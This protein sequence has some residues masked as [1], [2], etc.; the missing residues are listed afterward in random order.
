MFE[1][2]TSQRHYRDPMPVNEAFDHLVMNIGAHFD[3]DCV[4]AMIK[5]YNSKATVPYLYNSSNNVSAKVDETQMFA[6]YEQT[7]S[8]SKVN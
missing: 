5:Y 4:E 7:G 1:A 8:I 3:K 2:L 6:F